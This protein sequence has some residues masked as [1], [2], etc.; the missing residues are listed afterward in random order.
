MNCEWVQQNVPLYLYNELADDARHEVEQHLMRCPECQGELDAMR[1]FHSA[2]SSLPTPEPS[3]NLLAAARMRLQEQLEQTQQV[4]GWR[5][6]VLDPMALLRQVH[7]SPALASVIFLVGFAGGIGTMYR[8]RVDGVPSVSPATPD[9]SRAA[10]GPVRSVEVQPGSDQIS[11]K[12][13]RV[14][15]DEVQGPVNDPKIQ[16]LLDYAARSNDNSGVRLDSVDVLAKKCDDP[17]LRETMTYSLR[18]DS[19]PGV[20]LKAL[21]ALE[22]YVKEDIRVRNAVLEALLN[23][24]NPGVRSGAIHMLAKVRADTSVRAA[25]QQLAKEDPNEY[26][27]SESRRLLASLPEID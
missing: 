20:R 1:D 6:F 14:V 23:D 26:I 7:F 4:R 9:I 25:L 10:V 16:Q 21:E 17:R 27:R 3:P 24:S 8:L 19:N 11:I 12:F 2:M 13:D 5:R 22:P 18:Y 15:P